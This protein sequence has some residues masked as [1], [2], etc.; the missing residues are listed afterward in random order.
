MLTEPI[1]LCPFLHT[2]EKYAPTLEKYPFVPQ[3]SPKMP[4]IS[5][6]RLLAWVISNTTCTNFLHLSKSKLDNYIFLF[7]V[8]FPL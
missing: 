2:V 3:S 1:S 8:Y 7:K 6:T 4:F 5:P